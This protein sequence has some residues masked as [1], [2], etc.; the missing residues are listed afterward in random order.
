MGFN[1]NTKY[2]KKRTKKLMELLERGTPI[3]HACAA[4][5][6]STQT[7][8]NWRKDLDDFD[9]R[10]REA[11]S[12][13]MDRNLKNIEKAA[14]GSLV[15]DKDG[16]MIGKAGDW[17]AAAWLLEKRFPREYGHLQRFELTGNVQANLG[18]N[19]KELSDLVR[20]T[21]D[22]N[23]PKEKSPKKKSAKKT[24]KS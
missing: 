3:K 23:E 1:G 2:D 7:F 21:L 5:G 10:A 12:V 18:F 9:F 15:E 4:V 24:K 17:R 16:K 8:Y 19:D 14:R 11:E 22:R 20:R 6:I 13:F